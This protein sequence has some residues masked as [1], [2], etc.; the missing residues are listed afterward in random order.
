MSKTSITSL[1]VIFLFATS[2]ASVVAQV[3]ESPAGAY[4]WKKNKTELQDGYVV[5]KSGKK[6]EGKISLKGAPTAVSE[7]EFKGEGKELD[8]PIAS[9]KAYGLLGVNANAS[10]SA[11]AGPIN[12][13]PESMYEWRSMGIVMNKEIHSTTPRQGYMVLKDGTRYEGELKLRKKDNVLEDFEVK[14]ESGKQKA[15][16]SKVARYGYTISEAEVAQINLAKQV[17]TSLPGT[18]FNGS[19]NLAG[20][21]TIKPSA[22]R[23]ASQKIIFTGRDGKLTEYEPASIKGFS[24]NNKG[25]EVRFTS[26]ENVFVKELYSG[27]TFHVYMNPK[28]T[29]INT[30]ATSLA[31]GAMQMGTAAVSTAVVKADAKKNNYT[32]NMDS[33]IRVSSTEDLIALRDAWANAAGYDNADEVL[34]QSDNESLKANI[35]ALELAI[36]GREASSAP[37]GILN[38]EWVIF[39]KITNEKT[40]VYKNEFKNQIDVLLMGCDKYL[41]IPKNQQNEMQKWNNFSSTMKFLDGCY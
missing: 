18:I 36:A 29:S 24:V 31:K 10:N 22:N 35:G 11:T 27:N 2:A 38:E 5:L 15:D 34:E 16:V 14:T 13:S 19:G 33:I 25:K 12:E 40:I 7:I 32:T 20:E 9:L 37:G 30:F 39:N 3:N 41:E 1:A 21:I 28:P 17:K 23:F 26:L 6:M 4:Q 8:F